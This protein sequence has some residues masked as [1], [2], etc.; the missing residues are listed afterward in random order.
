M[1]YQKLTILDVVL[2]I[3]KVYADERGY[4]M[5]SFRQ[6]EFEQNCGN[7]QF[8]Q[9]NHSHSKQGV[10]RGLHYQQQKAQGKLVRVIQGEIF[11]VAVDMRTQSPTFGQWVGAY[12][13]EHN[14]HMLWIPPGFAHGFLVIS[15]TAD[16]AYKCTEYYHPNDEYSLRWNDK[17][18]AIEWPIVNAPI[19]L[20]PKDE[21]GLSFEQAPRF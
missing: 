7:Y 4:F 1:Q 5:E 3:P 16:V 8:V 20:S 15:D 19:S 14:K 21:N 17:T 11:D 10:L 6:A 9:D 2:L 12:L 13:N 18:I